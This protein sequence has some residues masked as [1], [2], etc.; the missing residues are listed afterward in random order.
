MKRAAPFRPCR[1]D[2]RLRGRDDEEDRPDPPVPSFPR[3]REST[4]AARIGA[5]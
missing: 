4:L 5:G 3:K 1:M 2:P